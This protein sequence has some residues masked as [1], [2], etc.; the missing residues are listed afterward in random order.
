MLENSVPV[1]TIVADDSHVQDA[2]VMSLLFTNL[3][4]S[5]DGGWYPPPGNQNVA[6][7]TFDSRVER[8]KYRCK[9]IANP[10]H[11]S[12]MGKDIEE[13]STYGREMYR[14]CLGL[15]SCMSV[16]MCSEWELIS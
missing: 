6:V 9:Y 7:T 14:F 11:P 13:H 2:L 10:R 16:M 8:G 1:P 15:R 4:E 5:S 3:V 12:V